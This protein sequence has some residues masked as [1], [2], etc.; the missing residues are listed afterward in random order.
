MTW[1]QGYVGWCMLFQFGYLKCS[2]AILDPLVFRGLQAIKVL[3][4]APQES[5]LCKLHIL[6]GDNGLGLRI[7]CKNNCI[8]I[9]KVMKGGQAHR[10]VRSP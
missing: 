4:F 2:L 3:F 6:N 7:V 9:R 1:E 10:Y 8:I 5:K